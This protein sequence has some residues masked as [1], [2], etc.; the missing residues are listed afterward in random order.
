MQLTLPTKAY[1]ADTRSKKGKYHLQDQREN[2]KGMFTS[3]C[4]F[5]LDESSG[6]DISELDKS[7]VCQKCFSVFSL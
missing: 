2:V 4:K 1:R 3:V 6:I 5:F 7:Q